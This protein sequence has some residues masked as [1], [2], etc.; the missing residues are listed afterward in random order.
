MGLCKINQNINLADIAY[1]NWRQCIGVLPQE[2]KIFNGSV[3]DNIVLGDNDV[4]PNQL[5]AFFK[6]YGFHQFFSKFPNS[7]ATII[8]EGGINISG[9]QRQLVALARTLYQKPQLLILDEPTAALDRDTEQF[10]LQLLD[11]LKEEMSIII[12]THRLKTAK[13]ADRIYI[14]ENGVT[15]QK[16]KHVDLLKCDNLYSRSWNDLAVS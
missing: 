1:E 13:N 6:E 9:G 5:E 15:T 12:L 3:L 2:I 8:G 14:I 11:R 4:D 16:G 10:V 7:Y